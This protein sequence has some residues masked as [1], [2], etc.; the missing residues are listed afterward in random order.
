[1][2]IMSNSYYTGKEK[3]ATFL[4]L[5]AN[6]LFLLTV[7][8]ECTY[9]QISFEQLLFQMKTTTKGVN[10]DLLGNAILCV[11]VFSV[12]ITGIEGLAYHLLI[13]KQS[14]R[15]ITPFS[16]H[17]NSHP[18]LSSL[19][20]T[21]ILSIASVVLVIALLICSAATRIFAFIKTDSMESEFIRR[22][23]VT[24][25]ES[26][27]S[28]P[29][30]KR[31]LIYI[32][33]E[34]M[35]NTYADPEAEGMITDCFIPELKTL[36]EQNLNFSHNSGLGG[37]LPYPG[38]TWTAAAMVAQT[39]GGPVKISL[40]ADTYGADGS[41]LPG[42]VSI[43]Q[44]L[45]EQGYT[46]VLLLGSDADFHGR[47]AYFTE[48]GKY[49]ILDTCS[50]K[51][52]GRLPEDYEAWWGFE[53]EKLFSYAREELTRLAEDGEPFNLTMLT[54]DTHFPDGC[55][56]RAQL[57]LPVQQPGHRHH[58][59][60]T[61]QHPDSG[62]GKGRHMVHASPLRRKGRAPDHGSQQKQQAAAD[63]QPLLFFPVLFFHKTVGE[64]PNSFP[65][66]T[67]NSQ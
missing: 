43:G 42:A 56:F 47:E 52:A 18:Q 13:V 6:V 28:F 1:M 66:I 25:S 37:A 22:H 49:E 23:Y 61:Q 55:L 40:E 38:T 67:G 51:E 2:R 15:K 35:E 46:Q 19:I 50:L 26:I 30:Q 59:K 57:R 17:V 63:L 33:L 64:G 12:V 45:E 48:H 8:I 3:T 62:K 53:D 54:A 32:F 39:A 27:L 65:H 21:H 9:D 34:S 41:F 5:F 31:N 29:E 58:Y 7:W 16:P 44:F 14:N 10:T 11:G 60:A 20:R 36:A 4:L 24:P